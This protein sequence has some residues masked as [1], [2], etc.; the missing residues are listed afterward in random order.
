MDY[1]STRN[2]QE[3]SSFESIILQGLSQ[4]GGLY[5]PTEYPILTPQMLTSYRSLSYVDLAHQLMTPFIKNAL[6]SDTLHDLLLQS[7]ASFTHQAIAPLV[8]IDTNQWIL[9]LFHGPTLAFKDFALQFLGRLMDHFL[10]KQKRHGILLGATSGDTGSA[11]IEGCRHCDHIQTVILYPHQ[12]VSPFQR[13]QMTTTGHDHIHVLAIDGTFDDCQSIVKK[14]FLEKNQFLKPTQQ[15][16]AA[17]SINWVRIMAQTV[18][19]IYAALRLGSPAQAVSFSVPTGNFGDILAGYIT[20]R[21]GLP[22]R[23]LI[24][25]TNRNDILHRFFS[26]NQYTRQELEASYSPSMDIQISS[27]FERYL[28]DVLNRDSAALSRLM[29]QFH[30]HGTLSLPEAAWHRACQLFDSHRTDDQTTI[31]TMIY[32]YKK[33]GYL[34]DPHTACG[35]N[36]AYHHH[37]YVDEPMITLATAHP[38]KFRETI[39]KAG[40]PLPLFTEQQEQMMNATERVTILPNN[41]DEVRRYIQ[42]HL[43]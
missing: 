28:F 6:D 24:I 21:M 38:V 9:E 3:F 34:M 13:K 8:Q 16:I 4:D 36:S 33:T 23:Q 2:N 25:A 35:V 39:E 22:I 27:N 7:Y 18:Y 29:D 31:N 5:L 26:T 11:A 1:I 41:I 20:K 14:L 17:N 40:L 12:R 43:H 30:K 32:H 37:R 10:K 42:T 19:Y 15:L